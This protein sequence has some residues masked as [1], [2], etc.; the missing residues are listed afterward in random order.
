MKVLSAEN[1]RLADRYTIE[2]EPVLSI[3]LME[4]AAE[5]CVAWLRQNCV[6]HRKFI[7]FC[8]N[9]NNGGDG[10]AIA[11]MLYQNG[12]DVDVL[13]D[14]SNHKFSDDAE[15]NFKRLKEFSGISIHD[16]ENVDSIDFDQE[17][18]IIDALYGTGLSRQLDGIYMKL[19]NK[20]N[21]L[22]NVKISIDIPSGLFADE[23]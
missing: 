12:C 15:I 21:T 19:I 3:N 1:I 20:L 11:R 23:I 4:R 17:T 7:L 16:F 14:S 8:G 13:I 5:E 10:F 22:S 9:G 18:I 6:H 2:N